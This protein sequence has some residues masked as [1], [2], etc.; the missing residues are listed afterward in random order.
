MSR[1]RPA[2]NVTADVEDASRDGKSASE[3]DAYFD[4]H[5]SWEP[6]EEE[7]KELA[8]TAEKD[9]SWW[10]SCYHNTTAMVGAGVLSLPAS[11]ATL[12]WPGGIISLVLATL[13]SL[14]TILQLTWLHEQ[15]NPKD[16]SI[17]R[18]NRYHQL[19]SHAF[20][21]KA[22]RW[23][24]LPFQL[25]V[26]I[27]GAITYTIT[28]GASLSRVWKY[29]CDGSVDPDTNLKSCN[30]SFGLS[31]WI[32][33]YSVAEAILS[34]VPNFT[35][36][37]WVSAV[38]AFASLAYST[39]AWVLPLVYG[40]AAN[41]S[42]GPKPDRTTAQVVFG[43]FNALA[44]I[45]FAYGGH[46]MALEIQSTIPLKP[47]RRGNGPASSV[48]QM[49]VGVYT[50]YAITI[51]CYF[52]VAIFGYHAFGNLVEGN[53]LYSINRPW[54]LMVFTNLTVVLHVLASYQVFSFIVYDLIE[55]KIIIDRLKLRPTLPVRLVYR[56][57]YVVFTAFVAC[58]LPFF[59]DIMGLVGA[60]GTTPTS[61]TI[62]PIVWLKLKKP[63]TFSAH[64]WACWITIVLSASVGVLGALGSI[65]QLAISAP[66]FGVFQR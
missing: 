33:V 18:M 48:R 27:G 55:K 20:G 11:F 52:M 38:G 14:Y 24:L 29:T 65:Y 31:A 62:P 64:W 8:I 56:T 66:T 16:G 5:D 63:P 25:M 36:L 30:T 40:S 7:D 50:A 10:Q 4:I 49:E 39:I 41:V 46:N 59:G 32:V 3:P 45:A 19:T 54:Q 9:A 13:I 58:L 12:L 51:Y 35:K 47:P 28:G 42:Y 15:R 2:A 61:Y 60:L 26:C 23:M 57:L 34:Q 37:G 21:P 1:S 43:V 22:G 53:V 44:N 6:T 17:H